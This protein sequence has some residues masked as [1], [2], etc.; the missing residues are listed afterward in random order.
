[1]NMSELVTNDN[2]SFIDTPS[3]QENGSSSIPNSTFSS[4]PNDQST[5]C[6]MFTPDHFL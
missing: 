4:L 6:L 2:D 3:C 1:M 5:N